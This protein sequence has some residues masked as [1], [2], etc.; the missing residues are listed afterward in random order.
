MCLLKIGDRKDEIIENCVD[1]LQCHEYF[2]NKQNSVK[3]LWRKQ[4]NIFQN[5]NTLTGFAFNHLE[6]S[7][8]EL[9]CVFLS[10]SYFFYFRSR[11]WSYCV[12]DHL[13]RNIYTKIEKIN[14][15]KFHRKSSRQRNKNAR[16]SKQ[17][18]HWTISHQSQ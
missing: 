17:F 8:V 6:H 9:V 15:N 3:V 13:I 1:L 11:W 18:K 2:S 14:K 16:C 10:F 4:R 7:V 5:K 12:H